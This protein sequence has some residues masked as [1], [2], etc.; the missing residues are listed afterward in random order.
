MVSFN[1]EFISF[2]QNRREDKRFILYCTYSLK[3]LSLKKIKYNF[4]FICN[5]YRNHFVRKVAREGDPSWW[6]R[7]LL[8]PPSREIATL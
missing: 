6:S 4:S 3:S 8:E 7:A 1:V 2:F 5:I